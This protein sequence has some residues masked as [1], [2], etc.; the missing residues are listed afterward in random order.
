MKKSGF[1]R[2]FLAFCIVFFS[3]TGVMNAVP[4]ENIKEYTLENGLT[5]FVLQDTSTPLIRLEYTARA[6][7]SNQ[8]KETSGFF[9]LYTRIFETMCTNSGLNLDSADCNADSSRYIVT[10]V[11]S[12][13][14][15]TLTC[16]AQTAFSFN[17][18]D[19]QLS[20]ELSALKKETLEE[21]TSAGGFINAAIDSRVFS[22]APWK[23]DSGVY[24]ALFNKTTPSKARN[25]LNTISA[26]W[27]TP[28]NSALFIS[29]NI[30]STAVME[31]VQD[32]FGL[33]YS[34]TP[35][36]ASK[37]SAPVNRQRKFVLHS[38]DFSADM[39]QIVIQYTVLNIEE[40]ELAATLLNNDG[41]SFKYA[42][43]N[44]P[45]LA[46]P[47]NEYINA[48]AAHKKDS[49][50]L[51]IQSLL[52]KP[53]D[54][55]LAD[56]TSDKQ[57]SIFVQTAAQAVN[58]VT[59]PE[60]FFAQQNSISNISL[61][62]SSSAEFMQNLS[63]YWATCPYDS[64]TEEILDQTEGSV[65]A[66][67]LFSRGE[68][69]AQIE[70][71]SLVSKLMSEEPF[72]FVIINSADY[73]K[74]KKA[75][76]A[77]G[78]E[79]INSKNAAWYNQAVFANYKDPEAAYEEL[80]SGTYPDQDASAFTTDYYRQNI[81][82]IQTTALSNGIPLVTKV[83]E[84]S[85]D[86]VLLLS[87]RGGKL[88]SADDHGFE[89]V[90]INLLSSNIQKEINAAQRNGTIL[91][92]PYVDYSCTITSGTVSIECMPY[93]FPA[94]CKAVS[95][96][97]IYGEILPAQADRAVASAQYKKRL[98]NGTVTRQM[99]AA[100]IKELYPKTD[101][102][103]IFEAK[104]EI[105]TDT[106]YQKI[107]E[108]YPALLDASRYSIIVTG[109]VPS[110]TKELL[111]SSLGVLTSR[112]TKQNLPLAS[113]KLKG[114]A[115][116]N[117]KVTHT[118]LTDIPAEK[119]G[120]MPAKLIPTTKYL[121]PVIY[122]FKLE[123]AGT[124]ENALTMAVL[125]YLEKL[126]NKQIASN[127]KIK[128]ASASVG[129]AYA[130]TDVITFT[131]LNVEEPKEADACFSAA[132]TELNNL[133]DSKDYEHIVREIKDS[134]IIEYLAPTLTNKGTA[135][136]L[137]KG[138]EYFPYE[139]KPQYY[140]EEF[141]FIENAT[142]EDFIEIMKNIPQQAPLRFYAK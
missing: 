15:S 83:N 95:D 122:V 84:N 93:D 135:Q 110:N 139:T 47:G 10:T 66:A 24:P 107:L 82:T 103:K 68:K 70:Q 65:T 42:L 141:N 108:G 46:I 12:R 9:K 50:R 125:K 23:H 22:A 78:F 67:N 118:F 13:L 127:K 115:K 16:L 128:E 96:A 25:I 72:V 19:Q 102:P 138:F 77:A 60:Y 58:A 63:S 57:V 14:K 35:L 111:D 105:L 38:P 27:Y 2:A 4:L 94:C 29:G 106:S 137:Q 55:K 48:A 41:S 129:E 87:I 31:L 132:V 52:Q 7:F 121:D 64:F 88:N 51:I 36:T 114:S 109:Q 54:K 92:S 131:I 140:L 81:S 136:L 43:V 112:N 17:Y 74:N 34:S 56:I 101:F 6:G 45:E 123:G 30:D 59:P 71:D 40:T 62:N 91:G 32:T 8:T 133:L 28:Q 117:V 37:S 130:N 3:L 53:E 49:S 20:K 21:A 18:S 11:P 99:L 75:Y 98:E 142:R 5:V 86:I 26:R 39:T 104:K 97:I 69:I 79:E 113:S 73:K 116:K 33:Y 126:V 61:I 80:I 100:A 120:P 44:L 90:M 1:W 119:A 85:S 124:K 89:E 76:T 134:W